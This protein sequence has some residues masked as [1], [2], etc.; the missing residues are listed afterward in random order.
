MIQQFKS[1]KQSH[2][3]QQI[4]EL[5]ILLVQSRELP[6]NVVQWESGDQIVEEPSFEVNF[7]YLRD[8]AF[9]LAGDR[10]VV[11]GDEGEENIE[12]EDGLVGYLYD[13]SFDRIMLNSGI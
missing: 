1:F 3:F 6:E 13:Y 8:L 9:D 7:G 5:K 10:V 11:F 12:E 2:Q 4:C